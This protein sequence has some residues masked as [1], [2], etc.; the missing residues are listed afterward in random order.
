MEESCAQC[1][2][3]TV[4]TCTVC[5]YLYRLYLC[6][7]CWL[8]CLSCRCSAELVEIV[9]GALR[10][11]HSSAPERALFLMGESFGAVLALAVAERTLDLPI[12]LILVNPGKEQRR[13]GCRTGKE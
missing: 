6:F 10:E 7:L 12:T 9:E 2:T 3:F 11:E 13:A 1:T 8:R 4:C 5:I